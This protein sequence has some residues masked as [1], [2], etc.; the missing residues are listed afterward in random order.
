MMSNCCSAAVLINQICRQKMLIDIQ[1]KVCINAKKVSLQQYT[2]GKMSIT[3]LP[4]EL[5]LRILSHLCYRDLVCARRTCVCPVARPQHGGRP[6]A[7]H[8]ERCG[9]GCGA[10]HEHSPH[11][12]WP[13]TLWEGVVLGQGQGQVRGPAG[14]LGG[15]H[16]IERVLGLRETEFVSNQHSILLYWSFYADKQ[17]QRLYCIDEPA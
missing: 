10:G 1:L 17:R 5:L 3:T 14:H 11:L 9:G 6:P 15:E 8:Q 2:L 16:G 12:R 7:H 13:G 4:P